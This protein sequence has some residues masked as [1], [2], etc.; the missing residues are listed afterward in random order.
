MNCIPFCLHAQ[1]AL[2]LFFEPDLNGKEVCYIFSALNFCECL[3]MKVRCV[4]L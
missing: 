3:H 4:F 1:F 2:F